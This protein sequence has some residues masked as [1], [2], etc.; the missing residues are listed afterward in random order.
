MNKKGSGR[1]ITLRQAILASTLIAA[2]LGSGATLAAD[3]KIAA[4][5]AAA[6]AEAPNPSLT[7]RV[8]GVD[9]ESAKRRSLRIADLTVEVAL[10]GA[11]ARTTVTARFSNPTGEWLEGEFALALPNDAVVTSYALDVEGQ[12]INGVLS[13]PQKAQA[14]YQ[15]RIR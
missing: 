2:P 15:A 13:E 1:W 9:D 11:I 14:A 6:A 8:G 3:A 7:A 12:M 5:D 4:D 10:V